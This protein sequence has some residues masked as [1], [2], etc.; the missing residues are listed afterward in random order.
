MR[1]RTLLLTLV[2]SFTDASTFI[3]AGR[4][5]SAHVT[6]NFI[7]LTYDLVH[8]A[9]K[10]EWSKLLAFPMFFVA[11][12]LAG[13]VDKWGAPRDDYRLLRIEGCLLLLAG[14]ASAVTRLLAWRPDIVGVGI[15][16][17]IIT[18]MGFQNAF[19]RLYSKSVFGPT[20]VMTGNVTSTALDIVQGWLG[21]PRDPAKVEHLRE[22]A[23]MIIV[24]L[25]GSLSGGLL[26]WKI[27]LG[28]VLLPAVLLLVY[29]RYIRP[30][31]ADAFSS[32]D[33]H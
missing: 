33:R 4:L 6:G 18:A 5:F 19:G 17:L 12:M 25:L 11:V 26:A 16:M 9:D 13:K 22:N 30:E 20:T 1:V 14:L 29:F 28:A 2:A 15:D 8:G 32:V 31:N 27:G 24:F 23:L 7:V 10:H 21:R 3:G